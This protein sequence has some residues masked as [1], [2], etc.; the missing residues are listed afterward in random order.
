MSEPVT[1]QTGDVVMVRRA[2]TFLAVVQRASATELAIMPCDPA[3]PDRRVRVGEIVAV[4]RNIGAPGRP[5]RRLSP[6][7]QLRLDG[8]T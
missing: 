4:Y 7:P 1:V 8:T 5:P 6:S 2:G 3:V